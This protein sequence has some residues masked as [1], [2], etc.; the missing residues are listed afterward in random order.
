MKK[1]KQEIIQIFLDRN[2][3]IKSHQ[4]KS[5]SNLL[6]N[7]SDHGIERLNL[8]ENWSTIWCDIHKPCNL[9]YFFVGPNSGFTDSRIIFLWLKSRQLFEPI[10]QFFII[11]GYD[12]ETWNLLESKQQNQII[13]DAKTNP[14][15]LI[16]TRQPRINLKQ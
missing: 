1:P 8:S 5:E 10:T 12:H 13:I 15:D 16:Y 6:Y 9:Y 4:N 14:K 11:D 2:L 7:S 3:I